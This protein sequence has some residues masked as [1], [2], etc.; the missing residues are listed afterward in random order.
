MNNITN[1]LNRKFTFYLLL[2]VNTSLVSGQNSITGKIRFIDYFFENAS[3]INWEIQGDTAVKIFL[4]YDY[5]RDSP[6]RQSGHWYFKVVAEQGTELKLIFTNMYDIYNGTKSTQ[7]GN[8]KQD[9]SCYISYD[10]KNWI[11]AKTKRLPHNELFVEIPMKEGAVYIARVPP[12]TITD[13]ENFKKKIE[14]S[15]FIKIFDIGKS[16]EERALEIIRVGN[17]DAP[18]SIII[19]VR[20]HPWESAS[21]WVTEGLI[22][23]L[24]GSGED[25]KKWREKYCIYVM[26]MANKDGVARGMTRF[27]VSGKD[28]NRNWL[29]ETDSVLCP[30]KFVFEKFIGELIKKGKRP[31]LGFDLHNDDYG[32]INTATHDKGDSLFM[33]KMQLFER[34]LKKYTWFSEGIKYSWKSGSQSQSLGSFEDGLGTRYGIEALVYEFNINWIPRLNKIPSIEDWNSLG[35]NLNKVFYDYVSSSYN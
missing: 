1:L 3:P 17:P 31:V 7:I 32:G 24:I 12:Y 9:I 23:K 21:N 11:N 22:N 10:R 26:P 35:E 14:K 27:N 5:E 33:K 8:I 34:L 25:A 15:P 20:A 30:E 6:N 29:I 28:M 4:Q 13:L 18:N 2:L 16:V 19:R